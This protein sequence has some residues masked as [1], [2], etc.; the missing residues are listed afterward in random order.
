MDNYQLNNKGFCVEFEF[1]YKNTDNSEVE[2]RTFR[3][4]LQ[5]EGEVFYFN[6]KMQAVKAAEQV[7]QSLIADNKYEYG[8]A[9]IFHNHEKVENLY[10]NENNVVCNGKGNAF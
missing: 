4:I 10:F 7:L 9:I 3:N 1:T 5:L 2:K 8:A 6:D